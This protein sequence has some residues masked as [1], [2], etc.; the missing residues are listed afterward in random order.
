MLLLTELVLGDEWFGDARWTTAILVFSSDSEDVLLPFDELGD[1]AAGALQGG[2]DG[3][4][5]SLVL[6][7]VFLLQNVVQD[8]AATIILR[9]LPV[10]DDR[11]VPD[12]IKGEVNRS[13]RFVCNTRQSSPC[14]ISTH[15]GNE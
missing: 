5:A 7:V 6:L 3:D 15:F 8:L 10:T 13:T 2:S 14:L 1:G 11:R 9:R 12:L 4:P